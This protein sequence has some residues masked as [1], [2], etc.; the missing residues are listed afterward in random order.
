MLWDCFF[1]LTVFLNDFSN[2][3]SY[4]AIRPPTNRS[5]PPAL[6][7]GPLS[8]VRSPGSYVVG[9]QTGD[10]LYVSGHIPMT[11]EG[12]LLTGTVG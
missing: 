2:Q 11:P 10:L 8:F 6:I 5:G 1:L 9:Y 12:V 4:L 3:S 7:C